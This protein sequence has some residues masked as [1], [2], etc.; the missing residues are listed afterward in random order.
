MITKISATELARNLKKYLDNLE[1]RGQSAAIFRSN[2]QIGRLVAEDVP[3]TMTAM[4]ALGDIYRTIPD[5]V[6]EGWV[7]ARKDLSETLGSKKGIRDP[8]DT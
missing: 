7:E 6:A 4:E 3:Q 8:W 5:E 1:Y 2:R